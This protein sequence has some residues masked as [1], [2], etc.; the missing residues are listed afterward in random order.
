[1]ATRDKNVQ[2]RTQNLTIQAAD[3]MGAYVPHMKQNLMEMASGEVWRPEL[4]ALGT[5]DAV[6]AACTGSD[7]V[8]HGCEGIH[9]KG[10]FGE[11][12]AVQEGPGEHLQGDR[13]GQGTT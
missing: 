1:M 3:V 7:G 8:E 10:H 9:L 11:G 5:G 2:R 13:K 6:G 12:G 4:G